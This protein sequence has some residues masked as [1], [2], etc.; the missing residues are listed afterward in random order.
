[1]GNSQPRG[2]KVKDYTISLDLV[3]QALIIFEGL[4]L[5]KLSDFA[6]KKNSASLV[7]K[8]LG[9]ELKS[10]WKRMQKNEEI[11]WRDF[12]MA[13][14]VLIVWPMCKVAN[15]LVWLLRWTPYFFGTIVSLLFIGYYIW[16]VPPVIPADWTSYI[17]KS[18]FWFMVGKLSVNLL[19]PAINRIPF[20]QVKVEILSGMV[21]NIKR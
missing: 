15:I 10:R 16:N 2:W 9:D 19:T 14:V 18:I 5:W 17:A 4:S 13:V 7:G 6:A 12:L 8:N 3:I 1:M 20:S 11:P 21:N